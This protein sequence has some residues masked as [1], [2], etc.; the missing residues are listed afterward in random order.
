MSDNLLPMRKANSADINNLYELINSSYRGDSARGGWTHE[1]DLVDGFRI[2]PSELEVI[3]SST[4]EYFLILESHG[5]LLGAVHVKDEEEG[6]YF[7][8]L[9]VR[10]DR[11]NEKIGARLIEEINR[12]GREE[13]KKYIRISV[14]HVRKELIEYY[15]RKGFIPTGVSEEFPEKY[16]AKITGLRL[17][18]MKKTL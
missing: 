16:P 4:S 10:P 3:I 18:E 13:D 5:L 9:A 11:Q 7:G 14:L 2:S 15:M 6:L 1:A 8:M 17:L 12:I